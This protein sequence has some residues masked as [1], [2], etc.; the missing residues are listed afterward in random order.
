MASVGHSPSPEP[1]AA[2]LAERAF[3]VAHLVQEVLQALRA[4][5]LDVIVSGSC[6]AAVLYA[7]LEPVID[8]RE[9]PGGVGAQELSDRFVRLCTLSEGLEYRLGCQVI[10]TLA[11]HLQMKPPLASSHQIAPQDVSVQ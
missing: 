8:R 11:Q 7:R 10:G 2:S 3:A 5:V 4:E 6:P 1:V 9:V